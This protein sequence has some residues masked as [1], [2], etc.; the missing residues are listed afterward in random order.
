[1]DTVL[2]VDDNKV[3]RM[4]LAKGLKD[5]YEVLEAE[6]GR[7]ALRILNEYISSI[8]IILLDIRMPEINGIQF[9]QI[10]NVI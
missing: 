3:N 6:N 10:L 1:M 4:I 2:I 8:S 5:S 9:L 7:V